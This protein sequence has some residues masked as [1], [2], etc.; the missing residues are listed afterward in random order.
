MLGC[1]S[2]DWHRQTLT[3]LGE[4]CCSAASSL[5]NGIGCAQGIS[6]P[7]LVTRDPIGGWS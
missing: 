7:M 4:L 5:N 3:I 6:D 2:S 1:K